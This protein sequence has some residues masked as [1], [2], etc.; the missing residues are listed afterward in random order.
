MDEDELWLF[1]G[2]I[3]IFLYICMF[4]FISSVVFYNFY[5]FIFWI[6]LFGFLGVFC[7]LFEMLSYMKLMI[8]FVDLGMF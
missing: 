7:F 1:E 2:L 6:V 3:F 8:L 5:L 4:M